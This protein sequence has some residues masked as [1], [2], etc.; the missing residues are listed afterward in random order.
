MNERHLND[1]AF[2]DLLIGLGAQDAQAHLARCPRCRARV[3][4]F[5]ATLGLFNQAS[6]SWSESRNESRS[7]ARVIEPRPAPRPALALF[8][9]PALSI[10]V[11]FAALLLLAGPPAWR[12]LTPRPVQPP[13]IAAQSPDTETQIAEDNELMEAVNSAIDPDVHSVVDQYHLLNGNPQASPKNRM[14]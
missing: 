3:E 7:H 12:I 14:E 6:I 11:A 13:A 5:Q 8:T 9:R 4:S 10:G 2:D 1:E